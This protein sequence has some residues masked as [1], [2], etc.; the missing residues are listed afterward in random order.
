MQSCVFQKLELSPF[1]SKRES[2]A[3]VVYFI[4]ENDGVIREMMYAD[5]EALVDGLIAM[6]E[7]ADS[8]QRAAFV[9]INAKHRIVAC[10]LFRMPFDAEGHATPQWNLPVDQLCSSAGKGPN[11]GAGPIKLSTAVQCS[12]PWH[13]AKLWDPQEVP[14]LFYWL[15][16]AAA[17]NQLGIDFD[18]LQ[19]EA[20]CNLNDYGSEEYSEYQGPGQSFIQSQDSPFQRNEE[21]PPPP[22]SGAGMGY[23]PPQGYP[24][25]HPT[26]QSVYGYDPA[27]VPPGYYPPVMPGQPPMHPAAAGHMA[28]QQQPPLHPHHHAPAP[29]P[30]ERKQPNLSAELKKM[31]EHFEKKEQ[32]YQRK[33]KQL[34]QKHKQEMQQNNT[35]HE[36]RF[37]NVSKE[38]EQSMEEVSGELNRLRMKLENLL[39][40]KDSLE[41]I[42]AA[43]KDQIKG[44]TGKLEDFRRRAQDRERE[45][46]EALTQKY[47]TNFERT[48]SEMEHEYEEK[49]REKDAEIVYR[50]EVV[51]HLRKDITNMRRDKLRL[52]NS[53]G[54]KFLEQLDALGISFIAYHAG[55]GHL[56]IPLADMP[57]Y[58]E[59]PV[60]Y[61]ASR[62]LVSEENYREWLDHNENP[63]CQYVVDKSTNAVCGCTVRKADTPSSFQPGITNRCDKHQSLTSDWGNVASDGNK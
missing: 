29:A 12:V 23:P 14:N 3:D 20:S 19:D 18:L 50:Q 9:K 39:S 56:S 51:K 1:M 55:A 10:V 4:D 52:V 17:E 49:L 11:M 36:A 2:L 61:A 34:V 60:A 6:H 15:R 5:F 58:M 31:K 22:Y 7:F 42:C 43:Q 59:N 40:Q 44:L 30:A 37:L 16:D 27:R 25:H 45:S 48:L 57:L 38:Y 63:V 8:V 54:D 53:G 21:Q 33:L 47:E 62:C 41:D 13:Q 26:M 24:P 28:P 46:T 35:Q 32:V